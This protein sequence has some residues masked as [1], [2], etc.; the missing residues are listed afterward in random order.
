MMGD[1]YRSEGQKLLNTDLFENLITMRDNFSAL[2]R[3][4]QMMM[5]NFGG[6]TYTVS[7]GVIDNM[8]K[9][10]C[11]RQMNNYIANLKTTEADYGAKLFEAEFYLKRLLP[12]VI[13]QQK[14]IKDRWSRYTI[15]FLIIM[16][17][18]SNWKN[19]KK[20][21]GIELNM[22]TYPSTHGKKKVFNMGMTY[23]LDAHYTLSK[24]YP[25]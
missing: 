18:N 5:K 14:S 7:E 21:A 10:E 17:R 8:L 13:D 2:E 11:E 19:I 3:H 9:T 15:A 6:T 16:Y 4:N 12:L 22:S 25:C 20:R 23:F 1:R 24:L